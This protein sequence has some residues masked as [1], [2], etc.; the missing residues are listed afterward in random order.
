MIVYSELMAVGLST[1]EFATRI[2]R[3]FHHVEQMRQDLTS[4]L[5]ELQDWRLKFLCLKHYFD[6]S[7]ADQSSNSNRT[8]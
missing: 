4:E 1:K 2:L 3:S 7:D 8:F 6:K 5:P